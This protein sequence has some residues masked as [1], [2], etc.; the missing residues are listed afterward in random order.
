MDAA[1]PVAVAR[2]AF[3]RGA[4][5]PVGHARAQVDEPP[6]RDG[7]ADGGPDERNGLAVARQEPFGVALRDHVV[8]LGERPGVRPGRHAERL[9]LVPQL[10]RDRVES[11]GDALLDGAHD[12]AVPAVVGAVALIVQGEGLGDEPGHAAGELEQ[13]IDARARDDPVAFRQV[14]EH[15][16]ARDVP[17]HDRRPAPL[18]AAGDA[19]Q[20]IDR[21]ATGGS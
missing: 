7:G 11:M 10:R 18:E 21:A 12:R 20:G 3:R 5:E 17:E 9:D 1:D 16:R 14:G 15:V 13:V 2:V 19:G 6:H 4:G 8:V